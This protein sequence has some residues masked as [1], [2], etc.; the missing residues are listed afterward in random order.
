MSW[1]TAWHKNDRGSFSVIFAVLLGGGVLIGV[2]ALAFDSG[3][4]VLERGVQRTASEAGAIAVAQRCAEKI[5][6]GTNECSNSSSARSF[7][8]V[9]AK[10]NSPDGF[11]NALSACGQ[12]KDWVAGGF[13]NSLTACGPL[14]GSVYLC[15]TVDETKY[16][17][18]VRIFTGTQDSRAADGQIH[19]L[20]REIVGSSN[21]YALKGCAQAAWGKAAAAPVT[22]PIALPLGNYLDQTGVVVTELVTGGGWYSCTADTTDSV[23]ACSTIS[24]VDGPYTPNQLPRGFGFIETPDP[25]CKSLTQNVVKVPA[26]IVRTNTP[27]L[28]CGGA[29]GFE[30]FL[31]KEVFIP[32]MVSVKNGSAPGN[33]IFRVETFYR[34][35]VRGLKITATKRGEDPG[36][37]S[38][39]ACKGGSTSCVY[40]DFRRGVVP[41]QGISQDPNI[42]NLG[43]QAVEILP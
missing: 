31:G 34:F 37:D 13:T 17:R 33:F 14:A 20:S 24:T 1:L 18:Y 29:A 6:T 15:K 36:W 40:G 22:M 11:T 21:G 9:L 26:D 3:Q 43:V 7:A 23:P 8:E 35:K 38:I 32:V 25:T 39:A 4:I 27:A 12:T 28:L 42:P 30:Y 19:P 10:L 2:V 16:G 41:G 5:S